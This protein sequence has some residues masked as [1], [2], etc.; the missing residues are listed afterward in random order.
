MAS[1]RKVSCEQC[2]KNVNL[3]TQ[4][5]VFC[6]GACGN[7]WHIPACVNMD[8]GSYE[9]LLKNP[10]F[11]WF[12]KPCK[13]RQQQR[14]STMNLSNFNGRPTTPTT[15]TSASAYT[16]DE[17]EEVS[18]TLIYMKL[19]E[20]EIKNNTIS[21]DV[22]KIKST[23]EDYKRITDELTQE[24][25]ELRNSNEILHSKIRN[26]EYE[27][28]SSKQMVLNNNIIISGIMHKE[29]ENIDEIVNAVFFKIDAQVVQSDIKDIIR[30]SKKNGVSGLPNPIIVR[31]NL[32]SKRD[33]VL[34]KNKNKKIE[35][36]FLFSNETSRPIYIGEELTSRR[37]FITK[38]ARDL[39]RQ[40]IVEFVWTK[41]GDVFIRKNSSSPAVKIKN[42]EQLH[43]LNNDN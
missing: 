38:M 19:K 13:I 8:K 29:D 9:D 26:I 34:L 39:R 6:E 31:F 37:Q 1:N 25:L 16:N 42:T 12:C 14:R 3:R 17:E 41:D 15:T 30:I 35:S 33:E 11:N 10:N 32:K 21:N 22:A 40:K 20:I 2:K 43:H 7:V 23:L 28:D 27:I 36:S 4:K 18:L 5:H 24:N